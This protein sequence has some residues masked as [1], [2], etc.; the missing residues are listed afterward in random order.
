MGDDRDELL[1]G[2]VE[3]QQAGFLLPGLSKSPGQEER[4]GQAHGEQQ[5]HED[6]S[7]RLQR[8]GQGF[9][10]LRPVLGEHDVPPHDGYVGAD[11][12]LVAELV[13]PLR[14]VRQACVGH[15]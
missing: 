7:C 13:Q 3:R 15:L 4:Q 5:Q 6:E 12:E 2:A 1:L 8:P 14:E 11:D 9:D 10:E